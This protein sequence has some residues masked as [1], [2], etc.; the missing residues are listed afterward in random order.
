M[1]WCVPASR[2]R[3]ESKAQGARK[4]HVSR[5][6]SLALILT[7]RTDTGYSKVRCVS[8]ACQAKKGSIRLGSFLSS[9]SESTNRDPCRC[10]L[11]ISIVAHRAHPSSTVRVLRGFSPGGNGE[12]IQ[13][14]WLDTLPNGSIFAPLIGQ[15]RPYQ[16]RWGVWHMHVAPRRLS[17]CRMPS[18][19]SPNF[20]LFSLARRLKS[21]KLMK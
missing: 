9:A 20:A 17:D 15:F 21:L 5:A 8:K 12:L 11:S 4:I 1:P 19:L 3:G 16:C 13:T 6:H 2:R 7:G 18:S 14:V 10:S